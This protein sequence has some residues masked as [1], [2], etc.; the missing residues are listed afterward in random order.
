MLNESSGPPEDSPQCAN[1]GLLSAP[2]VATGQASIT[3]RLFY[4]FEGYEHSHGQC[5][6]TGFKDN[7]KA[8]ANVKTHRSPATPQLWERHL[9]GTYG[10]GIVPMR[11]DGT[12]SWGACDLDDYETDV[13][14][15]AAR[16]AAL[17]IPALVNVS[18]SGGKHVF[19]WARVPVPASHMRQRLAE[20]AKAL[21]YPNA[22][23]FPK[24]SDPTECGGNWLNM[25]WQG[26]ENS[27]RYGV[28]SNG[29]AYRLAEWVEAAERLKTA[30]GA[31]WFS[32][33]VSVPSAPESAPV[34]GQKSKRRA[35]IL[36]DQIVLGQQETTM[37]RYAGVLL[38][39]GVDIEGILAALKI[40]NQKRCVPVMA[41][42]DLARIAGS[43]GKKEPGAELEDGLI[44]RMAGAITAT[45]AF[46]RD[47]GGL[48]YHF[49]DGV[50]K[51]NGRRF[52]EKRVKQLCEQ[53]APKSWTPE[54]ATRVEAW[55]VVDAP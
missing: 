9:Q 33:P 23:C 31:D 7:G 44:Q 40:E 46:A 36:P 28:M 1:E 10:L 34:K 15:I 42:K 38:R 43:I 39:A 50:Y 26:G 11:Q 51:P 5:D 18:R 29:D 17:G 12:C 30:T 52:I 22:E 21:G 16:V 48:L 24:Q 32:T 13:R 6:V 35:F 25:P 37:T 2:I 4:L 3:A 27:T 54:L 19:V 41:D 20:V 47:A 49:V 53:Q 8:V 45:D 14:A 55:I